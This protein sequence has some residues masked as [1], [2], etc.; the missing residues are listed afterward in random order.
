MKAVL[1]LELI[2]DSLYEFQKA[3]RQGRIVKQIGLARE[4]DLIRLAPPH[5]KP[6]VARLEACDEAPGFR[7][8]FLRPDQKDYSDANSEGS[9]GVMA[10]YILS[11]GI[12]EVNERLNWKKARRYYARVVGDAITEINRQEAYRC[13][14]VVS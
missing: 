8:T 1:A 12:Y 7:R 11:D 4:I 6:W 2:G 5:L 3:R 14:N 13:L 10:Y 9:R